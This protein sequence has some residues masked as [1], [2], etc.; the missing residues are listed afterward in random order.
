LP[1]SVGT[2]SHQF[3][4]D[5]AARRL[6]A[7]SN[8]GLKNYDQAGSTEPESP[9]GGKTSLVRNQRAETVA[10]AGT[11]HEA[12]YQIEHVLR[13]HSVPKHVGLYQK[14]DRY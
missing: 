5:S 8:N 11:D 9:L 2:A 12:K 1:N 7:S 4:A 13:P 6:S 3:R 10:N 14:I